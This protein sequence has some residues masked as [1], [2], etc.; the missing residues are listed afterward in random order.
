MTAAEGRAE[1]DRVALVLDGTWATDAYFLTVSL[2]LL[3]ALPDPL[4]SL[5]VEDR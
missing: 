3:T 1:E 5:P 2:F 4:A